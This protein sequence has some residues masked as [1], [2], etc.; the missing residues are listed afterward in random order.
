MDEI[1]GVS[2]FIENLE[3]IEPPNQIVAVIADPLLQ[4]FLQ[5]RQID[6]NA[7][8][9][10][11]WLFAFFEDQLQNPDKGDVRVLEMLQAILDYAKST[12]VSGFGCNS[13]LG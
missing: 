8:R 7:K 13:T 4:K 5:L 11:S 3:K 10:D 2:D 1:E 12:R 6:T 9:V